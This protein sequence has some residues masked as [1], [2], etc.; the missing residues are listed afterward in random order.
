MLERE[1]EERERERKRREER[2]RTNDGE[3]GKS[4]YQLLGGCQ[5]KV[6]GKTPL[7]RKN[8]STRE[9]PPTLPLKKLPARTYHQQVSCQKVEM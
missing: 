9:K 7:R 2:E 3:V 5:T 6:R 4:T 8:P 1:R